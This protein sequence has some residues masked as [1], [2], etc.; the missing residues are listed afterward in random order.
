[1]NTEVYSTT[2]FLKIGN[3]HRYIIKY[4]LYDTDIQDLYHHSTDEEEEDLNAELP[5]NRKGLIKK[6]RA[7]FVHGSPEKIVVTVTNTIPISM[8]ATGVL[9]G[10]Y[11][12]YVDLKKQ[13]YDHKRTFY[14]SSDIPKFEVNLLPAQEQNFELTLNDFSDNELVWE[15]N[16][17][18]QALFTTNCKVFYNLDI[19]YRFDD[20]IYTPGS[21]VELELLKQNLSITKLETS[22]LWRP[23]LLNNR[24]VKLKYHLV[25]L[26]HGMM[27]NI[28]ADMLYLAEQIKKKDN[29]CVV[30]GYTDNVCRTERGIRYQGIKNGEF[31]INEINKI[32]P[33]NIAK[34]S[35]IGHSLGG[36]VQTF[37][38]SYCFMKYPEIMNKL[39]LENFITLASPLLGVL[40]NNP[41]Y[42]QKLL[43]MGVVGKSGQD[44]GLTPLPQYDDEP[45]LSILLCAHTRNCLRKFK[46]RTVY[47]N[48][49]NDGVV[50]LYT[51]SLLFIDYDDVVK[52]FKKLSSN[53]TVETTNLNMDTVKDKDVKPTAE[54]TTGNKYF[55]KPLMQL[56]TMFAP[57]AAAK[58]ANNTESIADPS[59]EENPTKLPKLSFFDTAQH[60]LL[61]P[62]PGIKYI[63]DPET[64]EPT[65]IHD[66]VYKWEDIEELMESKRYRALLNSEEDFQIS[67]DKMLLEEKV[68]AKWHW[69][70][71]WRKVIVALEP[72]AHNNINVRRQ[73][74][75]AY[76]WEVIDHITENHFGE[77]S[78]VEGP[79]ASEIVIE[80]EI[81]DIPDYNWLLSLE[82]ESVIDGGVTGMLPT[83]SDFVDKWYSKLLTSVDNNDRA[84]MRHKETN[85]MPKDDSSAAIK[86]LQLAEQQLMSQCGSA[87]IL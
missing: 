83:I 31:I 52:N 39:H 29:N 45:F 16:I 1:M 19:N 47:A 87:T 73:F 9:L 27:S 77:Q 36:L 51:S 22:D 12:L 37:G 74:Q 66:R 40:N 35:F 23:P 53:V 49:I 62:V 80:E 84:E 8:R 20:N 17:V 76:G 30:T 75:N 86:D 67:K 38:L 15:M 56:S 32:K 48:S 63:V 50:P 7:S 72:D 55:W 5:G 78:K 33:E 43:T 28:T 2:S 6:R 3:I 60:V 61:Q 54:D 46:N 65:I 69:K 68:A 21:K 79:E 85:G 58:D 10:P 14:E 18:S 13:K 42:V 41:R 81:N 4:K 71:S 82:Q 24:D 25:V 64:R 34:I 57:Q 11:S 59:A 26:T 44:I 70:T